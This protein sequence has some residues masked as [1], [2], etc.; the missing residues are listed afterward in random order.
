MKLLIFIFALCG[1]FWAWA[2]G[3][4]SLAETNRLLRHP[5]SLLAAS[6]AAALLYADAVLQSKEFRNDCNIKGQ[7]LNLKGRALRNTGQLEAALS[8]LNQATA[9]NQQCENDQ[10]L[11]WS[12]ALIAFCMMDSLDNGDTSEAVLKP[13]NEAINLAQRVQD[14]ALLVKVYV[15]FAKNWG[16][17]DLPAR[18]LDYNIRCENLLSSSLSSGYLS[19]RGFNRVGLGNRLLDLYYTEED[20]STGLRLSQAI[21]AFSGAI[22]DLQPFTDAAALGVMADAK[23][24]LGGA[25][26]YANDLAGAEQNFKESLELTRQIG[27]TTRAANALYNLSILAECGNNFQAALDTLETANRLT[28]NYKGDNANGLMLYQLVGAPY[29]DRKALLKSQHKARKLEQ[30]QYLLTGGSLLLLLTSL[31]VALFYRQKTRNRQLLQEEQQKTQLKEME[32]RM[33]QQEINFVRE[34]IDIAAAE[35]ISIARKLHD[36]VGGKLISTKWGLDAIL[37]GLPEDSELTQKLT[38]NLRQQEESYQAAR[39]VSHQLKR[40]IGHW[41]E[42]LEQLCSR[43]G[44]GHTKIEFST[45][46][47]DDSVTGEI[48]EEVRIIVQELVINA[49]KSAKA[50][51]I[52]VQIDRVGN[53]LSI[54]VRDNGQGFDTAAKAS[55]I[56]LSNIR[57]RIEEELGGSFS[58]DSTIGEGTSAFVDIPLGT[59]DAL[60]KNPLK[61]DDNDE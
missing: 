3:G 59:S 45:H 15:N 53:L 11:A 13:L 20:D 7:A 37:K 39:D 60:D 38:E 49:L 24:G 29:E 6:P 41:W 57:E 30:W 35:R 12:W 56:G 16:D 5:D 42:Y 10:A 46:N 21:A 22:A 25:K 44:N 1:P 43:L 17:N 51:E 31:A 48:G 33:Q 23:N 26:L 55:G 54:F 34:K 58:I 8:A 4:G 14:T 32:N 52:S 9:L 27:D 2:Q 18:A 50:T 47:L 28:K 36:D 40:S 19:P 61:F